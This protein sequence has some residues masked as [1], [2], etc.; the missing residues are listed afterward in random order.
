M[1][2]NKFTI[3]KIF[4][5]FFCNNDSFWVFL[6]QFCR[7]IF[8]RCLTISGGVRFSTA[9][10][11]LPP[12]H[13]FK[14]EWQGSGCSTAVKNNLWSTCCGFESCRVLG[15][16]AVSFFVYLHFSVGSLEQM[17]HLWF[18]IKMLSHATRGEPSFIFAECTKKVTMSAVGKAIVLITA[19]ANWSLKLQI[20]SL[21]DPELDITWKLRVL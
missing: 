13:I 20:R 1:C 10:C 9:L 21:I 8:C 12:G 4:E 14:R 11:F 6:W 15:F 18:S 7:K 2:Q 17:L 5:R 19:A 3:A 16:L